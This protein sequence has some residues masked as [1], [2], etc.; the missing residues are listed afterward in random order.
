MGAS[1][2]E[3]AVVDATG[4]VYGVNGLY[5]ADASIL[6][7]PPTGFPHLVTLMMARRIT[8]GILARP[9]SPR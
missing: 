9:D 4:R 3:G 8:D 6:P 1:A 5:V 2:D 7:G